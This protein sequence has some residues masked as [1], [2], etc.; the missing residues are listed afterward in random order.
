MTR[1]ICLNADR[2]TPQPRGYLAWHE[3]AE[4]MSK[5]HVQERCPGCGLLHIW[6]PKQ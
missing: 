1:R 5:T 3:W 2:H 4:E 6:V